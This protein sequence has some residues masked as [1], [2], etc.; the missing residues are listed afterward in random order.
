MTSETEA[1]D[2]SDLG[3]ILVIGDGSSKGNPGPAGWGA[4]V[5]M[6][7]RVVE[8][9]GASSRATNNE[10]ELRAFLESL[11]FLNERNVS[12]CQIKF[13]WDSKFVLS[14]AKSWRFSWKRKAWRTQDGSEVKN[15]SLWKA[16]DHELETLKGNDLVYY[17]VPGHQGITANERVDTIAQEFADGREPA[18]FVGALSDYRFDLRQGLP[19][20]EFDPAR[21]SF[22]K[23]KDTS[24]QYY[25]SYVGGQLY[26][27][28][29]WKE[30]EARVKGVSGVKYK[31]IK[32]AEE[33]PKVLKDWGID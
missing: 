25:L 28:T 19:S 21:Q 4:L 11:K 15:L 32:S 27:D 24:G 16:I 6:E 13:Y 23:S 31:K 33:E 26:R 22:Q 3:E 14:G 18:L 29:T 7:G 2:M 1:E 9:G 17:Y 20:E 10:M 12:D 8:M 30:C 5:V